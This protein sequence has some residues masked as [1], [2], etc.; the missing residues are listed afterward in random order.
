[1]NVIN[2]ILNAMK[3]I[4]VNY[5]VFPADIAK[6]RP[7]YMDYRTR[8]EG[9]YKGCIK[10][11][12]ANIYK[13]MIQYGTV[14]SMGKRDTRSS[15]LGFEKNSVLIFR[16]KAVFAQGICIY[17]LESG[18]ITIGNNQSYNVECT[19][20][21]RNRICIGDNALWGRNV[22]VRDS[23]GHPI[24]NSQKEI[25]NKDRPVTIEENVWLGEYVNVMKGAYIERGSVFGLNSMATGKRYK[26]N[27]IYAGAPAKE[28][29][30]DIEWDRGKIPD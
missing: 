2:R 4:Y 25:I 13:G 24:Y 10:I 14:S 22:T 28:I 16:G 15:S 23:D 12:A 5:K 3:S 27:C 8:C 30:S 19:I 1:M 20:S 7:I 26:A 9:L 29:K 17:I 6:K 11:E 21:C 18:S